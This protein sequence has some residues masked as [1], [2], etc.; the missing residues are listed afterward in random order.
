MASS[1]GSR[2]V[3][4]VGTLVLTHFLAPEVV[5]EV[6]VAFA[7]VMTA[8]RLS[9]VGFGQYVVATP[10]M[11]REGVFQVTVLNAV[12][13]VAS[14]GAVLLLA[15]P[16]APLFDAPGMVAYVP[17]LVLA[18]LIERVGFMPERILAR[19]LRFKAIGLARGSSE[20]AYAVTSVGL[21]ALAGW[22]GEAIV[23][24]NIVRAAVNAVWFCAIVDRREWLSPAPIDRE[25]IRDVFRFGAPLWVSVNAQFAARTWDNLLFA[26]YFGPSRMGQYN[27]A[28]NLASIPSMTIGENIGDVLLPSFSRMD[29]K[30]KR[31]AL[32]RATGLMALLIFP[33]AVGFGAIADTLVDA[34]FNEE[35]QRVAPYLMILSVL[36]IVRPISW[37]INSYLQ[38]RRLTRLLMWLGLQKLIVL[39][40]CIAGL[41]LL[42]DLWA[43]VGVGVAFGLHT[44]ASMMMVTHFD[45]V[46]FWRMTAPMLGPLLACIPLY[47][48]VLGVRALGGD[49]WPPV[50]GIFIEVAAGALAYVPAALLLARTTS[51]DFLGLFKKSFL[52]RGR[53]SSPPA[54]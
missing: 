50:A 13:M 22:G 3:G 33:L 43:C 7:L 51:R 5:G 16:V 19:D 36:S 14:L 24:G 53:D 35:W 48:A 18:G 10:E 12:F 21:A 32:V 27:L 15:D 23:A 11:G 17:G 28:Y 52:R 26:A 39:M 34:L 42:G 29:D 41:G 20:V 46:P 47:G 25:R 8:R 31:R 30:G 37:V 38:S 44:I 6:A 1:V 54:P 45:E 9:T 4:V 2:F 40:G 49:A